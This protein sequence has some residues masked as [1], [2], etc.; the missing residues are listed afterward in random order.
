MLHVVLD[1]GHDP[2]RLIVVEKGHRHPL[3]VGE[4]LNPHRVY[5]LLADEHQRQLVD[6]TRHELRQRYAEE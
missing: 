6:V 1:P 5:H 2:A 3:E 4:Y